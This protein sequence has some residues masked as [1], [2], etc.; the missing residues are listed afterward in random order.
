M[1]KLS[2]TVGCYIFAEDYIR[3]IENLKQYLTGKIEIG[4]AKQSSHYEILKQRG[5]QHIPIGFINDIEIIFLHYKDPKVAKEKW[6]KRCSRI[7]WENMI[8]KFSYMSQ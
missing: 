5:Q 2:P 1:Q 7:N 3:M 4:N 6:E 8:L